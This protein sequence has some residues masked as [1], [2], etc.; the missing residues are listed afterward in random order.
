MNAATDPALSL[1]FFARSA[2]GSEC[3]RRHQ[4][5]LQDIFEAAT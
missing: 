3:P 5:T 1:W 4:S 2:A